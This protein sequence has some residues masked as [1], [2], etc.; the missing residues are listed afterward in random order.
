MDKILGLKNLARIEPF[1]TLFARLGD[2]Y[3]LSKFSTES[4]P[5]GEDNDVASFPGLNIPLRLNGMLVLLIHRSHIRIQINTDSH[6]LEEGDVM[7]IRPGTLINFT[8]IERPCEFSFLFISSAFLQEINIDINSMEFR[9]ILSR[10]R[11]AMRLTSDETAV[12]SKYF[13]LLGSNTSGNAQNDFAPRIAR[14]LLSAMVYEMLRFS[15]SRIAD[16]PREAENEGAETQSRSQNYVYRFMQLLQVHYYRERTLDFYARQ[17]CITP[18]YLS[19]ITREVTG[20]TASEWI[21]RVVI[22]EAKNMLRFS[23]KN[24]QEVAYALNFPSQS[25][26]GKYFKRVTGQSP[27]RYLKN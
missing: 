27:R 7:V 1:S 21:N 11:S 3:I 13:D 17:L 6:K 22:L 25:A 12:L 26:F 19:M 16:V 10:P 4:G 24:I 23:D 14:T 20:Q 18:K 15:L 5:L 8:D 9:S 2:L